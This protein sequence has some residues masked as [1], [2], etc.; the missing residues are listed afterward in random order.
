M[1]N[2]PNGFK[3]GVTIN[4][5]P[6]VLTN[7]GEVFFVSNADVL[8]DKNQSVAGVNQAG[9]GTFQRPFRTLD[10]AVG[11]CTASRGDLIILMPGHE[12]T[13]SSATALA[14][15]VA[16]VTVL[17]LGTG[18]LRP[19]FILDTATTTTVAVSAAN[20]SFKNIIF[21]ANFADIAELFTPTAVN[22]HLEDCKFTQEATNMNFVEIADTSTTDNEA[23]GLSFLRCE[24]IEPDT[25]T[26]SLVN[27]DADV[28]RLS[29]VDCDI[30]LGI[31][32]VLA[33]IAEVAAGKDLTNC[34][35]HNNRCTRLVTA[36]AV[37]LITFADTTT[38]N[39]G[40]ISDNFWTHRDI[41]GEL[42]LTAGTNV[43]AFNNYATG[44]I[45]TSGYLLPAADS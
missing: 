45:G 35:I 40:T 12:E 19:K 20:V 16:G 29:V 31:N 44:V 21:S 42:L 10:F 23:D 6:L 39:T 36:S 32:G 33:C 18:T 1:S 8:L 17:G 26:T 11:Q 30:N 24:W 41:A 38:T 3:D 25:A 27:V 7:P 2:Y 37:G 4:N 14:M 34:Y 43:N 9:G 28:D 5:V 15:D 22:L 13:L